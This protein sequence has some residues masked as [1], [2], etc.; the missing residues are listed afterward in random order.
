MVRSGVTSV[1]KD[2]F[3]DSDGTLARASAALKCTVAAV[4]ARGER[5]EAAER[6]CWEG[7][8]EERP[9]TDPHTDCRRAQ[10]RR[11]EPVGH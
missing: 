9:A 5:G 11:L 2:A 7:Y 4:M 8:G 6:L 1:R 10:N 3:F